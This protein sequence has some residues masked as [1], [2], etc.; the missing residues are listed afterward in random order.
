MARKQPSRGVV[1]V[2][3]HLDNYKEV[4]GVKVPFNIRFA[5]ETFNFRVELQKIEHN[6]PIDDSI[7][8]KP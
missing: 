2:K 5:F 6:I 1:F 8:R 4:D 7:F 3:V